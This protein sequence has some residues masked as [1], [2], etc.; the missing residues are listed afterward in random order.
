MVF[1]SETDFSFLNN[2]EF[3]FL[4]RGVVTKRLGWGLGWSTWLHNAL[5]VGGVE[6]E[7]TVCL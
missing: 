7:R 5:E 6:R 2:I 4:V 1:Y 3:D